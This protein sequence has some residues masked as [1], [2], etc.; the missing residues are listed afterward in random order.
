MSTTIECIIPE[1]LPIYKALLDKAA[2]YPPSEPYKAAA[3]RKVADSVSQLNQNIFE[4]VTPEGSIR[5]GPGGLPLTNYGS[6]TIKFIL[7]FVLDTRKKS[8]TPPTPPTS[9]VEYVRLYQKDKFQDDSAVYLQWTG[10][11]ASIT[12]LKEMLE[13]IYENTDP[14]DIDLGDESYTLEINTHKKYS[15]KS[16]K[17]CQ[18][19]KG[20]FTF[21]EELAEIDYKTLVNEWDLGDIIMSFDTYSIFEHFTSA[22]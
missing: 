16:I 3:Y 7:D 21:P 11:E 19:C 17:G 4:A 22:K 18:I 14:Y 20:V 2:T 5:M 12:K 1:N 9:P 13:Y 6:S 8:I 10:N 15:L